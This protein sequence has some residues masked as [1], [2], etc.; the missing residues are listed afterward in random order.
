MNVDKM[1]R[2]R[3]IAKLDEL[4][5][6]ILELKEVIE[7][8]DALLLNRSESVDEAHRDKRIVVEKL[9]MTYAALL[10]ERAK[11]AE[12]ITRA[13][14]WSSAF[15][16][17]QKEVLARGARRAKNDSAYAIFRDASMESVVTTGSSD[18]L[19]IK[20]MTER[21]KKLLAGK[22]ADSTDFLSSMREIVAEFGYDNSTYPIVRKI[23]TIIDR[24][25]GKND[26]EK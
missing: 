23:K 3:L 21:L 7:R 12:A 18:E 2:K 20:I 14:F 8:K 6:H 19:D 5:N 16:T 24:K 9:E 17:L 1:T 13:R 26:Q 10:A 22:V 11:S 25:A 15:E 4:R